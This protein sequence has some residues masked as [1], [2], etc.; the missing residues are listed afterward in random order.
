[1]ARA[2]HELPLNAEEIDARLRRL[3]ELSAHAP[4]AAPLVDVSAAGVTARLRECA[5]ISALALELEAAGA[6]IRGER[7]DRP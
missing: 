1:M 2:E 4:P 7:S 5:E 6:A 3:A